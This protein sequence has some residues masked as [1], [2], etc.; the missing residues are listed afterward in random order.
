MA[1][2]ENE[3][4]QLR[5]LDEY[6]LEHSSQ[7]LRG[8]TLLAPNGQPVGRIEDML[9]DIENERVAALRLDD[10]RVIDV[11]HVDIRDEGPVLLVPVE[12]VP[13]PAAGFDRNNMTTKHIPIIEERLEVAKRPI[14]TGRMR[15]TSRVVEEPVRK[16]VDVREEHLNVDRRP[17]NKTVTGAEAEAMLKDQN[18]EFVERGEKVVAA[19][20]AR[21]TDE[22]VVNKTADVRRE[23]VEGKVRHTE[24]DVDRGAG[25]DR[26]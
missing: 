9:V 5:S 25:R 18:V 19:K 23:T 24:V 26:T 14:E 13:R 12:R 1:Y 22:V 6:K 10:D 2:A 17:V 3:L 7:D 21:V 20:E 15:V 8:Q 4:Y 16:S 11:D